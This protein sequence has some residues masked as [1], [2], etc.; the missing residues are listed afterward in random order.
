MTTSARAAVRDASWYRNPNVYGAASKYH[1]VRDEAPDASRHR[2]GLSGC[3]IF[4]FNSHAGID[5]TVAAESVRPS[6][7]CMRPGYRVRWP[8]F[9]GES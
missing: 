6:M 8:E 2:I 7:R 1:V 9:N 5:N 4:T 3:N